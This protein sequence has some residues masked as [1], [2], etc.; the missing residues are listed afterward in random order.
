MQ[1]LR[2]SQALQQQ[3]QQPRERLDQVLLK[4]FWSDHVVLLLLRTKFQK[5]WCGSPEFPSTE[6]KGKE[7][8]VCRIFGALSSL[9]YDCIAT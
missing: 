6:A 3:Q 8:D 5:L 7:H 4:W 1:L 2:S 9:H